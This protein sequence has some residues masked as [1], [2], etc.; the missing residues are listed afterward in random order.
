MR[1]AAI[2]LMVL[3]CLIQIPVHYKTYLFFRAGMPNGFQWPTGN[4]PHPL[5][6]S[7]SYWRT[8][9]SH[10]GK[11]E[12]LWNQRESTE[13]AIRLFSDG[14]SREQAIE[15]RFLDPSNPIRP[16]TETEK[17]QMDATLMR[18]DYRNRGIEA[19]YLSAIVVVFL[20]FPW[21]LV[22]VG[23]IIFWVTRRDFIS[24][25]LVITIPVCVL[26]AIPRIIR[27]LV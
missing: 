24:I 18:W 27:L 21:M 26:A 19:I 12:S 14:V 2:T 16:L 20:I 17:S 6:I 8:V 11:D 5:T 9:E 4:D 22:S 25:F 15:S 13:F 1:L 23:F 10:N 3:G 7:E